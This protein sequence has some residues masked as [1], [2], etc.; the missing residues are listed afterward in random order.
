MKIRRGNANKTRDGVSLAPSM[1]VGIPSEMRLHM[2]LQLK[3]D[4]MW[5]LNDRGHWELVKLFPENKS[6]I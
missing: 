4:V 2:A 1:V 6:V 5:R 3:D